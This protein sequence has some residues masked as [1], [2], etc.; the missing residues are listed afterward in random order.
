MGI[1]YIR[2]VYMLYILILFQKY[3]K[4]TFLCKHTT[5]ELRNK[6]SKNSILTMFI[7]RNYFGKPHPGLSYN[8]VVVSVH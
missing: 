4:N 5:S 2:C 3:L 7:L 8:S 6:S 1:S